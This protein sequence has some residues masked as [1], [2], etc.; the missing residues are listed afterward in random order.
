MKATCSRSL[1]LTGPLCI[2]TSINGKCDT[3]ETF[4]RVPVEIGAAEPDRAEARIEL[5]TP[6]TFDD[7]VHS[8][9]P[10]DNLRLGRSEAILALETLLQFT[11]R[12]TRIHAVNVSDGIAFP[13]KRLLRN[14]VK[15]RDHRRGHLC[16]I[17]GANS[18]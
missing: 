2:Y 9:A 18:T 12:G 15:D 10:C 16:S 11:R 6:V 17:R 7:I 3:P 1:A 8:E 4:R 13:W 14:T 5:A